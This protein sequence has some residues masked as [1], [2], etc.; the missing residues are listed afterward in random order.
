MHIPIFSKRKKLRCMRNQLKQRQWNYKQFS[1]VLILQMLTV[2]AVAQV[3][4]SGKVTGPDGKG[5]PA[6]SVVVRNTTI[7]S[8]TD[9]NGAYVIN[10]D[11]KP[12]VHTLE[13]SGV[14]FKTVSQAVTVGSATSYTSD[15]QLVEDALNMEEVVVT[16]VSA[17]T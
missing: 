6:I 10:A 11:L 16:G 13:F 7:G 1:L 14:G 8:V 3:Q 9:A 5:V 12:G 4:L 2:L 17:G 15:V